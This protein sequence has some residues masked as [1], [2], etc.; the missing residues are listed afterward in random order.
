LHAVAKFETRTFSLTEIPTLLPEDE[1]KSHLEYVTSIATNCAEK[2]RWNSP[3]TGTYLDD[4]AR[5]TD[6]AYAQEILDRLIVLF[7]GV[8]RLE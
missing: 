1:H 7:S 5:V 4:F 6:Y 3:N 2:H 8:F